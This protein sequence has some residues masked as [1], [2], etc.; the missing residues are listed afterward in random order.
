MGHNRISWAAVAGGCKKARDFPFAWKGSSLPGSSLW[1]LCSSSRS[2]L[3]N[4]QGCMCVKTP[5]RTSGC[6][7]E[8]PWLDTDGKVALSI[9][10]VPSREGQDPGSHCCN[11]GVAG[12][13]LKPCEISHKTHQALQCLLLIIAACVPCGISTY[14]CGKLEH[15]G[16]GEEAE[17]LRLRHIMFPLDSC[18][19]VPVS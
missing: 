9:H 11:A 1:Q 10:T 19:H 6:P 18:P 12:Q 3:R 16:K 15:G 5:C 17:T 8:F 14:W 13:L 7:V 2:L 4:S